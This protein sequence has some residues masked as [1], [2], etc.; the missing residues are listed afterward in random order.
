MNREK[1]GGTIN[2]NYI[3][4]G[5]LFGDEGK[6]TTI[7]WLVRKYQLRAVIRYN[8]GPQTAHNG[9]S[10]EGLHH[11]FAQF[12]SGTLSPGVKT[13]LSRYM[14]IDPVAMVFENEVLEQKGIT[15]AYD[16]LVI[17]RG[18]VIVTPFHIILNRMQ[19]TAR[20]ESRHGSCGRGVGQALADRERYGNRVLL[21][22][23][24]SDSRRTTHKLRHVWQLKLEAAEQLIDEN[25]GNQ[26]L[27]DL[28]VKLSSSY[29]QE[30]AEGYRDFAS[31][32]SIQD[33]NVLFENIREGG[34]AFEGAQGA[35]LDAQ[36]GFWPHV[37]RSNTTFA[38]AEDLVA[39]SGFE[40]EVT[41]IGVLR[42]YGTRHGNG[43]FPTEDRW[44][45]RKVAPCHNVPNEWQ[46]S[47]RLGWFDL[48]LARY[49]LKLVGGIDY[50][51]LTN[52]DRLSGLDDVKV[53]IDYRLPSGRTYEELFFKPIKSGDGGVFK[54]DRTRTEILEKCRPVWSRVK[55]SSLDLFIEQSL[56]VPI[57][58]RSY[59]PTALDKV[60]SM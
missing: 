45:K 10:P 34:V 21:A 15:D 46:G 50:L 35:L 25:P 42:A 4:G 47:I 17:D 11:C 5:L 8:G 36:G 58:I 23:D 27:R 41:K 29:C 40:G 16:R 60:C 56:D 24:L 57:G 52:I 3:V 22:G 55:S 26:I 33:E 59:G 37:T 30:L 13:F 44:L 51:A 39:L 20:G 53:G 12:G 6:G 9:V 38:N 19:E 1:E 7:D 28:Y 2:K 31:R 32:V 18:C 14:A 43:P 54:P 49:A 48:V